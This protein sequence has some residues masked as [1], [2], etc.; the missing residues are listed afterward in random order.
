MPSAYKRKRTLRAGGFGVPVLAVSLAALASAQQPDPENL[1]E[2]EHWK[3]ARAIVDARF[4]QN[5][6]DALANFLLSQIRNAFGDDTSP[7]ALAEKAVSL[8]GHVAKYHRQFAEVLGLEARHASVF[9]LVTLAH[10]FRSEIDTA[11]SLDP[12]DVQAHRDLLEYYLVAPGIAGGDFGKAAGAAERIFALDISEGFLAKARIA[13]YR[14]QLNEAEVLLRRAAEA[15][16]ASYRARVEL[17]KFYL[18]PDPNKAHP[19]PT[20]A[21][22]AANELRKIDRGRVVPYAVL[23]QVYAERSDWSALDAVL[24]D[25]ARQRPDDLAPFTARPKR[26]SRTVATLHGPSAICAHIWV[27][28]RKATNRPLPTRERSSCWPRRRWAASQAHWRRKET[29]GTP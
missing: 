21:E 12:H 28:N 7:R 19:N 16:P 8:D 27:R 10:Q 11:I 15:Q 20:A 5:P 1:I 24:A 17:A 22:S 13:S 18:T 3:K 6:D 23:A 26:S 4:R 9:R 2:A 14:K 25:G 29:E